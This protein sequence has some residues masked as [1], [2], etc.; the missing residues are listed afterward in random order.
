MK[1]EDITLFSIVFLVV[2]IL[3]FGTWFGYFYVQQRSLELA[4]EQD[5][6]RYHLEHKD[7]FNTY[8]A[9]CGKSSKSEINVKLSESEGEF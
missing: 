9:R 7:A 2:S 3:I 1:R 6:V 8:C 5:H 4:L